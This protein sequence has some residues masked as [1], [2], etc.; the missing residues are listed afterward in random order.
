MK[1]KKVDIESNEPI[2]SIAEVD[3][4]VDAFVKRGG[5]I[6]I[7]EDL[8]IRKR[9][10]N[11]NHLAS[12]I[13]YVKSKL[14]YKTEKIAKHISVAR[15]SIK[16]KVSSKNMP[17]KFAKPLAN[18]GQVVKVVAKRSLVIDNYFDICKEDSTLRP[19]QQKAKKEI[20][21]SWDEVDNV[22]FQLP[23]G[24][25]KTRCCPDSAGM[26]FSSRWMKTAR[27][28]YPVPAPCMILP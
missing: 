14:I 26:R 5:Y 4:V 9:I 19:Y 22:M 10:P 1:H 17:S 3:R 12:W 23:T 21:E 15:T 2:E 13:R 18:E 16:R 6:T 28:P 7:E 27:L 20:F 8:K 25:G 24:T 11:G